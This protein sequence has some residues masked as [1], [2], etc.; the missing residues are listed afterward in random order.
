LKLLD[1]TE[2]IKLKGVSLK[3]A[4]RAIVN[5]DSLK[6]CVENWSKSIIVPQFTFTGSESIS[7]YG[8]GKLVRFNQNE[9]KGDLKPSSN[10][11]G[12][13]IYPWTLY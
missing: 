5:Y 9:I 12:H 10:G 13:T 4:H 7:T 3:Q 8:F 1:G 11:Q 2:F 6:A